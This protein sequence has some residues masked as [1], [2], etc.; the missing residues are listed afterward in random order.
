MPPPRPPPPRPPPPQRPSITKRKNSTTS[1]ISETEVLNLSKVKKPPHIVVMAADG[2]PPSTPNMPK[3]RSCCVLYNNLESL[4]ILL[5]SDNFLRFFEKNFFSL[6]YYLIRHKISVILIYNLIF[7]GILNL[8]P[9][10]MSRCKYIQVNLYTDIT[11]RF[12]VQ[13]RYLHK[14]SLVYLT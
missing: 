4:K 14:I 2:S 8:F 13:K 11:Y 6:C 10:P 12:T 7:L 9:V 1:S 3:V 5:D